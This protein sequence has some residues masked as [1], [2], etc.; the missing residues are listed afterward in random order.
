MR[1]RFKN[2]IK[3]GTTPISEV[4][5][6]LKSRHQL[7]PVLRTLQYVFVT[8]E[9]NEAVFKILEEKVKGGLKNTG[10]Y[11][12]DLWQ[13]LVLGMVRHCENADFDKLVDMA[14]EHNSLRG[15]LGVQTSDYSEGKKFHLQ[16]IKDNVQL[17][18]EETI[19]KISDVI[20][21][22]AHGLIKKKEGADS[23]SL[24]IKADSFVVES[25]IHFPTDLNLLWDSIRKSVESIL[26][27][28]KT[29][30]DLTR[31]YHAKSWGSKARS[32][33]RASS[34][35]HRK[36][37]ANYQERLETSVI[38]YLKIADE[39]L[40]RGQEVLSDLLVIIL[41]DK[42]LSGK[43]ESRIEKFTYYLEMVK[44]HIDLVRRRILE[45]EKIPHNEKVFSIF[46]SHVEWN[47]K[48]KANKA[49]E[50]GHNVLVAT[51]QY[52]FVLYSEVYES[53]V[54]KERTIDLC[55]ALVDKYEKNYKLESLSLD[56]NFYSSAAEKKLQQHFEL[57][58]LPKAGRP[59]KLE[60][61][62]SENED[63]KTKRRKHSGVE[64]NINQLEHNSLDV[65]PDK[66][67]E[68]FKRYVA[69]G[70][71]SYNAHRMGKLLLM[72]DIK[73]KR[74][75]VKRERRNKK[76]RKIA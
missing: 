43:H 57:V 51:D 15:I 64:G 73:A 65:C 68:G 11:G 34:E 54:D 24:Q 32:A 41:K 19:G 20:V 4:N 25:N 5:L 26:F 70:V 14:N 56:R 48:G 53:K 33:Y 47:S 13:I 27:F 8:P 66:G 59:S 10:R 30:G 22:G 31:S 63:Y 1:V 45:G 44:K 61:A 52:H 17:L 29:I 3:I 58:I 75:A 67:I 7:V 18:D 72:E 2:Q 71:L 6:N 16:T 21:S 74:E 38:D 50:L 23:L 37:G 40:V 35:I 46:E 36:K 76:R 55:N 9:L 12:M 28:Q 49:V 42:E 60:L 39:I 62:Q 69:Y